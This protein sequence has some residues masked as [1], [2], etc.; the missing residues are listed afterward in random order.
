MSKR[1]LFVGHNTGLMH[2]AVALKV[3]VVVLWG[4]APLEDAHPWTN[5]NMYRV[6]KKM[7]TVPNAWK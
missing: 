3:P 7:W 1:R 2:I 4:A 5:T 6:V